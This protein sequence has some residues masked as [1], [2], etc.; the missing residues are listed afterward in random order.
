M[1]LF[2]LTVLFVVGHTSAAD[3]AAQIRFLLDEETTLRQTLQTRVQGLR[4]RAGALNASIVPCSCASPPP[5]K[6]ARQLSY[7]GTIGDT[8]TSLTSATQFNFSQDLVNVGGA[9]SLRDGHFRAPVSG[10]YGLSFAAH[11]VPGGWVGMT[12]VRENSPILNTKTG[13]YAYSTINRQV[14][15]GTNFVLVNMTQGQEAWPKYSDGSASLDGQ[16]VST[17]SGFLLYEF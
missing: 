16:G 6:H 1:L 10:I 9:F 12:L 13:H 17:F 11:K 5:P 3:T 2:W 7:T 8:M 4:Q 15:M 14:S